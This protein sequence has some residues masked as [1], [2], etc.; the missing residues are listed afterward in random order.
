MG[1]APYWRVP[2]GFSRHQELPVTAPVP[3]SEKASLIEDFVD[4]IFSPARVFARRASGGVW[5]PFLIVSLVFA[6]LVFVNA[7]TMQGVM[8]AEM[9]RAIA[10]MVE[11]NPNLTEEQLGPMRGAMEF[12]F[13]WMPVIGA[14][15]FFCILGLVVWLVGKSFGGT[16]GFG[17]GVMIAAYAN[18]PRVLEQMLVA[19]QA[20]VLDTSG[21]Q[22]RLQF[23]L[24]VGRF[25]DPNGPQGLLNTIGRIDLFTLWATTL[26]VLGLIHAGKVDKQKAIIG[27]V[28]IWV[29]GAAPFA[30]ALLQGK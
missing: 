27:G 18:V 1:D 17:T 14:P 10:Q 19:I 13:K 12:S 20:L 4:I 16:L 9:N 7:G 5:G 6:A 11:S 26:I 15:I 30:M 24:G 8:D 22:S 25:M 21:F 29:L 2:L 23:S 28:I 3:E